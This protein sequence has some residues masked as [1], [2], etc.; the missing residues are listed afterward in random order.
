MEKVWKIWMLIKCITVHW[1]EKLWKLFEMALFDISL[2]NNIIRENL[3]F[4]PFH[5]SIYQL[6][7]KWEHTL[8]MC[9]LW[10]YK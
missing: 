4:I 7:E 2:N 6:Y 9:N 8:N 3:T 1:K 10:A 5:I